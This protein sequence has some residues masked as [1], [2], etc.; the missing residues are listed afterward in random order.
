M[1]CHAISA[2]T[3]TAWTWPCSPSIHSSGA[4]FGRLVLQK[5]TMNCLHVSISYLGTELPTLDLVTRH[6][7]LMRKEAS[8]LRDLYDMS[9]NNST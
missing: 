4:C 8:I 1:R 2:G 6:Y 5:S 7:E 9:Y 3:Q